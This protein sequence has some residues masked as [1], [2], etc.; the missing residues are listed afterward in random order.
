M[1]TPALLADRYCQ[2]HLVPML[3]EV[4]SLIRASQFQLAA[5]MGTGGASLT[6]HG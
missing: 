5:G 1:R 3:I 4:S 6:P 2:C